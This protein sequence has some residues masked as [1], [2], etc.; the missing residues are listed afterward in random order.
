M[1]QK[2]ITAAV[3]AGILIIVVVAALV[4]TWPQ[5]TGHTSATLR[6][7]DAQTIDM[8]DWAQRYMSEIAGATV[9]VE[10]TVTV[11]SFSA[12]DVTLRLHNKST[13]QWE[14]IVENRDVTDMMVNN[15]MT[16]EITTGTYDEVSLYIGT[17]SLDISWTDILVGG[18]I[19]LS[20][21]GYD[22]T[23]DINYIENAGHF[24]DSVAVN[25]EFTLD[26]SP[27]VVATVGENQYFDVD[28]GAPFNFSG[29]DPGENIGF[30]LLPGEM[31][32]GCMTASG[33]SAALWS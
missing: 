24:S 14:N 19:D 21:Y 17:V 16:K 20:D 29:T 25:Q 33:V 9:T 1:K 6:L 27:N 28:A 10:G 3:M 32:A 30:N 11:N 2:G 23:F 31:N 22:E 5:G 15:D 18:T 13:G 12:T 8:T 26:L 4:V 7:H